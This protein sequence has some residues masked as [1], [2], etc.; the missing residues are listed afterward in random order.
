M[1]K[2]ADDDWVCISAVNDE[3]VYRENIVQ[4]P[5]YA[6][7]E[8][9]FFKLIG[10]KSASIA[11]NKAMK[12][13]DAALYI[14]SH[15]DVYFPAGWDGQLA[16]AIATVEETDP[17][18]GVLGIYGVRLDGQHA[19][20]VWA[21]GLGRELGAAFNDPVPIQSVDELLI[22]LRGGAVLAFDEG[23]PG[24]HLYGTD[25]T[26]TALSQ[27]KGAYVVH[28]PV[29]HNSVPTFTLSGA[30]LTSYDYMRRKWR[31]RLPIQTPV[32]RLT[33]SGWGTRWQNFRKSG[34]SGK[35]G[36][37]LRTQAEAQPRRNPVEIAKMLGYE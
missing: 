18:W 21:T 29:V 37:H 19:G 15:Q 9:K 32:T 4:S 35:R 27:G 36:H 7:H 34:F 2:L 33:Q 6:S 3:D 12:K 26:Q 13:N 1:S 23:L 22:V 14:L 17:E 25:I 5:M 8:S 31:D 24:F 30:F 28:A 16:A 20:R 11:Y 10:E